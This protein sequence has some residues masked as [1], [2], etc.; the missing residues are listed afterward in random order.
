VEYIDVL[1]KNQ[2]DEYPYRLVSELGE[3]RSELRKLE[4]FADGTVEVADQNRTTGQTMLGIGPIPSIAEI[5]ADSQFEG[6]LIGKDAFEA[7]WVRHAFNTSE[8]LN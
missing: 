8:P 6:A 2:P 4:F 1:W 3:D 7:L 5:N